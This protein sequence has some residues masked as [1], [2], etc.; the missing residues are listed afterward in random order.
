MTS[1]ALIFFMLGG[2]TG[3]CSRNGSVTIRL[4][5]GVVIMNVEWPYHVM[6]NLC[7]VIQLFCDRPARHD[8]LSLAP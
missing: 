1:A 5:P 4:P 2:H 6:P 8:N 7:I 3:F